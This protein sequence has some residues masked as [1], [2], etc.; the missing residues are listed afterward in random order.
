MDKIISTTMFKLFISIFK[1]PRRCFSFFIKL[2][3][4]YQFAEFHFNSS[5]VSPLHIVGHN[6]I[7]IGENVRIQNLSWI[8]SCPLTGAK[9][10]KLVIGS[11]TTIGHFNH[12]ISTESVIIGRNVLTA[13]KVYIS[14]N[15]HCYDDVCVPIKD[16]RIVQK[17]NV[18][19]GDNCWIG[20]N[21]C[22]IGATIGKHCVVGAN[23][24]VTKDVPDYS[25]VVGSPARIIKRY[26]FSQQ[27][28]RRIDNDGKFKN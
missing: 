6:R 12:I 7:F 22:I 27:E 8:Q 2:Y 19:I 10:C 4:K 11:N 1:I 17:N 20:E 21:V 3:Y 24:V 28:W 13:D 5:I 14:D 23:T 25:V 9:S 15:L 18:V 26:D 16:Q